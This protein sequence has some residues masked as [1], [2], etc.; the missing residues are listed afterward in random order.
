MKPFRPIPA[1]C[2]ALALAV[3][4]PL[5][6]GATITLTGT[7]RDF[8]S[9]GTTASGV[10]GHIDFENTAYPTTGEKGLVNTTLAADGK[11]TLSTGTKSSVSSAATF[12]QWYHDSSLSVSVPIS[13]VLSNS[14]SAPNTYTYT[15]NSFFPLDGKGFNQQTG[16]APNNHNF[17]FTTEFHTTF[18]YNAGKGDSF[19]F[20]GDDD[21]FVFINN[22]LAIDLG[23]VH[24]AQSATVNLDTDAT[25]LALVSGRTYKLDIFQAERRTTGSNFALTT[26]LTTIKTTPEPGTLALAG[27]AVLG[28]G[29]SRSRR[30]ARHRRDGDGPA[31]A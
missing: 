27:L 19:S 5:A 25:K 2:V 29:W 13:L 18:T 30:A 3:L 26:T 22:V 11:P 21:V 24:A 6:H 1:A 9:K 31:V 17:G 12:L 16:T 28:L 15:N 4:A 8:N 14:A 7:A 10:A 20:T 23:G